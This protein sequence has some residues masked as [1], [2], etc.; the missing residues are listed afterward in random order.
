M[1]KWARTGAQ[2]ALGNP[3][4]NTLQSQAAVALQR[5][6]RKECM[7]RNPFGVSHAARATVEVS[8]ILSKRP[9]LSRRPRSFEKASL[10]NGEAVP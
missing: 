9:R 4:E 3:V 7:N 6:S 2:Q 1:A 10:G 5:R 8:G